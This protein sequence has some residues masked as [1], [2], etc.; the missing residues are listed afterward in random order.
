MSGLFQKNFMP[1]Q[2]G[3][4]RIFWWK[5]QKFLHLVYPQF[6]PKNVFAPKFGLFFIKKG[7]ILFFE[8]RLMGKYSVAATNFSSESVSYVKEHKKKRKL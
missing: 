6:T 8:M 3:N 5:V 1:Q 2:I 4:V 7:G